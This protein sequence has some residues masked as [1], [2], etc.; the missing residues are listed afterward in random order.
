VLA[1]GRSERF[2][3]PKPLLRW[4]NTTLVAHQVQTLAAVSTIAEVLVVTGHGENGVR[5]ALEGLHMRIVHNADYAEGRATSVACGVKAA[6]EACMGVLIISVDQPL[7]PG[8]LGEL[9][10]QWVA[11]PSSIVRPTH[12]G[13]HGHPVIFPGDLR[14]ELA[15]VDEDTKG[16]RSVMRRHAARV[17]DVPTGHPVVLFNLN[18]PAAYRA[19]L[20][21]CTEEAREPDRGANPRP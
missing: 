20:A 1:A 15:L 12:G 5:V 8:S 4:G 18:S 9:V 19:A 21:A 16:L 3:S 17:R 6:H 14:A 10:S 7:D 2:G 13:R 11:T